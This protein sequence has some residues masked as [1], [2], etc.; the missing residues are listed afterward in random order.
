MPVVERQNDTLGHSAT[1][2]LYLLFLLLH[3]NQGTILEDS[4]L[5]RLS[6]QA[7]LLLDRMSSVC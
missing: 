5:P 1:E 2:K 4:S 3:Q 6:L 7:I